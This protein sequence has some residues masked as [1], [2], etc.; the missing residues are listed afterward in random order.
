MGKYTKL[1]DAYASVIKALN[2]AAL[3]VNHRLRL[4]YVAAGDLEQDAFESNRT[5]YHEAWRRLCEC[6]GVLVPGGFGH[7]GV[8]GKIAAAHWAR[9]NGK[10]FLGVCLG[11]QCAVIEFARSAL[12]GCEDANSTE[13]APSTGAPVVVDMPEHNQGD[14]GATMRLGRRKTIFKTRES[15]LR[16]LY[17]DAVSSDWMSHMSLLKA[18]QLTRLTY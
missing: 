12:K 4:T 18:I 10:P 8:E 6:Q 16:K 14:M 9:T 7:R 15:I 1:E 11:M 3:A 13:F 2:H 5:A 17:G